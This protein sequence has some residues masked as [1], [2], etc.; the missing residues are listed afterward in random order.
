MR[1]RHE[2]AP[3]VE[4]FCESGEL[5]L[6]LHLIRGVF[7]A[8]DPTPCTDIEDAWGAGTNALV[9]ARLLCRTQSVA[10]NRVTPKAAPQR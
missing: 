3:S 7:Q 6:R 10:A 5:I 2:S 1:A 9:C 4:A 8:P